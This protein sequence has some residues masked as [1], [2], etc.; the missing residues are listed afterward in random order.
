MEPLAGYSYRTGAKGNHDRLAMGDPFSSLRDLGR[1]IRPTEILLFLLVFR[2]SLLFSSVS[3][4]KTMT[5]ASEELM[6]NNAKTAHAKNGERSRNIVDRGPV[7]FG[8]D[9]CDY[10]MAEIWKALNEAN[11]EGYLEAKAKYNDPKALDEAEARGWEKGIELAANLVAIHFPEEFKFALS[12]DVHAPIV[13]RPMKAFAS[14]L[15]CLK[16]KGEGR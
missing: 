8:I 13:H 7:T 10:Y 3:Y 16:R 6:T 14:V 2:W 4:M 15:L 5:E 1:G 9:A 12:P 11:H